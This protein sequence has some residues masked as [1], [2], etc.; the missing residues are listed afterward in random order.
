MRKQSL[1][2]WIK[3]LVLIDVRM[4]DRWT[5]WLPLWLS[6]DFS[7]LNTKLD[8]SVKSIY[9]GVYKLWQIHHI[10]NTDLCL[11]I[12]PINCCHNIIVLHS[13]KI[14]CFSLLF[15]RYSASL[16]GHL[17]SLALKHM[18]KNLQDLDNKHTGKNLCQIFSV[19]N[20]VILAAKLSQH[21]G[22]NH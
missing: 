12:I 5:K 7:L 19:K 22:D 8:I 16:E 3:S 9:Q 6:S 2:S 17:Q 15:T 13:L 18:P 11:F 21:R 10:K 4:L 14:N 1:T 20:M